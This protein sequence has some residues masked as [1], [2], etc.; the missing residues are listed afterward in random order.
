[1]DNN[2]KAIAD[3]YLAAAYLSYGVN[4][5]NVDRSDPKRQKFIFQQIPPL[6]IV[7]TESDIVV[8]AVSSPS[9]DE[10]EMYYISKRLWLPPSYPDAIRTIK[11]AI[12][13]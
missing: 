13:A 8:K 6:S 1:M 7:V 2:T 12:R 10:L 9:L 5:I 3:M 11:S 4:L